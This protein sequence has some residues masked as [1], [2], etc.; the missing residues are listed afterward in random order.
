M[1]KRLKTRI[2]RNVTLATEPALS[3]PT[4]SQKDTLKSAP[5]ILRIFELKSTPTVG[6][7]CAE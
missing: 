3:A 4:I 6:L 2:R 7:Y 1:S 5:S